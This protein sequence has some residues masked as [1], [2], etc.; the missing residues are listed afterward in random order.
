MTGSDALIGQTVSH[1]R[2]IEKLG[3]G[4]MGV[5]YKAEDTRL[6][7]FVALKFLPDAVAKNAHALARF[8]REAQTASALNH[9]NICTIHDIGEDNGRAFIAMEFLEGKTLKH[10]IAGRPM[11][12]ERLLTLGIEIA[13]ALD[14]AH[15]KGI[16]HRDIKPANIFVTERGHA[17]ILDFGLAKVESLTAAA[18]ETASLDATLEDSEQQLTTPGAALG[19]VA[20][21]SPEQ[22]RRVVLDARTDLFSFGVVLYEMAT[23][24]LPFSGATSAVVFTAI[25]TQAPK[26]PVT[27]NPQLAAGFGAVIDK[28][29][30]KN[31]ESRY[32]SAAE[33]RADLNRLQSDRQLGQ[34]TALPAVQV[35]AWRKTR[36]FWAV[37]LALAGVFQDSASGQGKDTTAS[38]QPAPTRPTNLIIAAAVLSMAVI[39]CVAGWVVWRIAGRGS[40]ATAPVHAIAVMPFT[41][42]THDKPSEELSDGVAEAIIDTVSQIPDVR[43]MSRV[44]VERYRGKQIDPKQVGRDL[45]VDAVLTG[46]I[47]QHGGELVLSTELVK[48]ED[49]R[50]LWGKQ[51]Q[52]R[53]ADL[54]AFQQSIAAEISQRLQPKLSEN[55]K[56]ELRKLPTQSPEA[57]RLY[58][59]GRYFLDRNNAEGFKESADLFQ[60]AIASDAGFA[61]AY[62]GLSESE[63]L[64]AF[65]FGDDRAPELR[66]QGLSAAT[67]ALELD[68]SV[69][70]A[71]AALGLALF[72]DF[73]WAQA[74]QEL[75]EAVSRNPNSART[76]LISGWYLMVTARFPDSIREIN[77]ADA[78]EPTSFTISYTKGVAY[79][80]AKNY[81]GAIRQYEQALKIYPGNPAVY[82]SLAEVYLQQNRC[83]EAAEAYAH[84]EDLF[85]RPA[86]AVSVRR[87]FNATGCRGV[88]ETLLK[89]QSSVSSDGY[90]V[91]RA[92]CAASLLGD[93]E[94]AFRYL[95]QAYVNRRVTAVKVQPQF[96]N[97]RS[98][99]R[100][101]DL[102]RRIGLPQ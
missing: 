92:A 59:K 70:E 19:T 37:A 101:A 97:L 29:L 64:Q 25:L 43:V 56:R 89:I 51:Y 26:P 9:P 33:M 38:V 99:P 13:D 102:L 45:N 76:H 40:S 54:L 100:F 30:E 49:S 50:H 31:R 17:K 4:G 91:I 7:R 47:A 73:Q 27:L 12:L 88:L 42:E 95:E 96:D 41:T 10:T 28:A 20:Y 11:E 48:A 46:E 61:A 16:V 36:R 98:D 93:K 90:G 78:L 72:I 14:A 3:G 63:T 8:Q 67:K 86:N 2:I 23:G 1:Y 65:L 60:Q 32:Q 34:A 71:H 21:M 58:V 35:A 84:S 6:H 79:F 57:Y 83:A 44:S 80:Y 85:G 55:R 75:R 5:V 15:A 53:L 66:A 69:A 81:E 87:A 52:A 39:I 18:E 68:N 62:A 22:A 24:Q 94:R 77:E 74:E 82:Y